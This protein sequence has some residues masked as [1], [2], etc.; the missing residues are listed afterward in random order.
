MTYTKRGKMDLKG[1]KHCIHKT[2]FGMVGGRCIKCGGYLTS[3]GWGKEVK[4][5]F[6][7][8]KK[9]ENKLS[10]TEML[11]S[12]PNYWKE[13]KCE[14]KIERM[15]EIVKSLQNGFSYIENRLSKLEQHIH[16]KNGEAVYEEKFSRSGFGEVTQRGNIKDSDEVYF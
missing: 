15:R 7:K 16:N 9:A 6:N 11:A 12:R 5:M 14:E 2:F 4:K 13:L 3:I 1:N 10:G 8:I